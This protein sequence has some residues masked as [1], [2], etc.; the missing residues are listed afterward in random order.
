MH[1]Q[2]FVAGSCFTLIATGLVGCG[3]ASPSPAVTASPHFGH[4]A[5]I[6]E[7]N[8]N[9]ASVVGTSAMPYLNGLIHQYGLGTQYYANTH[10]SIG[11]YFMLT[12]GQILTNN[13]SETPSTFPVSADNI[14]HEL[15]IAGKTWKDYREMTGTYYVRH[16][17]LAYMTNIN[18]ANLVSFPQLATDLLDGT[19]PQL[20][21]IV[22]N[23]CDDAHDCPLSTADSWLQTNID[24]LIKNPAFNKDGL[25]IV[26]FDESANDNTDGGGR[27]V[28][29]L[30][31]PELSKVAYQ[32]TTLYQHQSTLRLMLESLSLNQLPGAAATAPAMWEFFSP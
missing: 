2:V 25:L 20:S 9:Y 5:I 23:G 26:V 8:T 4:V 27:V 21:W 11:N 15:E 13:D 22:P 16:D 32:S 30:I 14:A 17:P 19:L 1:F 7:E 28:V 31:S 24:P 6:V 3:G 12:T 10:P 18:S 29:V